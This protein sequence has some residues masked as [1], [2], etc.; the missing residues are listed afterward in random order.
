MINI[1]PSTYI[2]NNYNS[3]VSF[4]KSTGEP[5]YLTKNGEGELVVM[6]ISRYNQLSQIPQ[7]LTEILKSQKERE[8]GRKDYSAGDTITMMKKNIEAVCNGEV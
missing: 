7:V 1:K 8:K 2:R 6:D 3:V 4:C 5:I